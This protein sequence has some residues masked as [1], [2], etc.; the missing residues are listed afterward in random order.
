MIVKELIE[1][2]Q[3]LDPQL[4]ALV[5]GYEGGCNDVSYISQ[6]DIIRDVNNEW[7]YGAH[8]NVKNLHE[9]VIKDF[10]NIGKLPTKGILI[11]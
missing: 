4:P 9:N 11:N 10:E 3:A 1:K 2:L 6:I 8:E 5:N 7:Y